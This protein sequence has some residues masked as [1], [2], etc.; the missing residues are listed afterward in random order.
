MVSLLSV[1]SFL[2]G[3]V[4]M[5][6]FQFS[7][8]TAWLLPTPVEPWDL[9]FLPW[10]FCPRPS[11][12]W[13]QNFPVL[14]SKDSICSLLSQKCHYMVC[15]WS[16]AHV[17]CSADSRQLWLPLTRGKSREKAQE[18][19]SWGTSMGK[20]FFRISR[21]KTSVSQT[22]QYIV[23]HIQWNI[24]LCPINMWLCAKSKK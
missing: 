11:L 24:S 5:P 6:K 18:T 2:C 16:D 17:T 4:Y 13:S 22:D 3:W 1:S 19:D 21:T 23:V 14:N 10:S 12:V 8:N 15:G 7:C 20:S 9:K